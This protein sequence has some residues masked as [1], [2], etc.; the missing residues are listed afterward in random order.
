MTPTW[1]EEDYL[2]QKYPNLD[3]ED[4]VTFDGEGNVTAEAQD[5]VNKAQ[6]NNTDAT[7]PDEQA[8][9]RELGSNMNKDDELAYLGNQHNIVQSTEE[10]NA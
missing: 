4:K 3:L 2:R 5:A 6:N 9:I 8:T 1:E 10:Q 7:A